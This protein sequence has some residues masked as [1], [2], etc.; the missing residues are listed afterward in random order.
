MEFDGTFE[1]AVQNL[2]IKQRTIKTVKPLFATARVI[3]DVTEGIHPFF[4]EPYIRTVRF[5]DTAR[6]FTPPIYVTVEEAE[7]L[8][9]PITECPL[10]DAG[11]PLTLHNPNPIKE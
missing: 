10:C 3:S 6:D 5:L 8:S 1:E 7:R 9:S 4:G 11:I 2:G